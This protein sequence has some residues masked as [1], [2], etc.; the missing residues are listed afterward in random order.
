MALIKKFISINL[1]LLKKKNFY[2]QSENKYN[3]TKFGISNFKPYQDMQEIDLAPITLIYGQNSGG[4]TSLIEAL[5]CSSQSVDNT[6]I[7]KGYFNLS[8]SNISL[9]TYSTVKNKYAK[10]PYI[11][12]KFQP[13]LVN[14]NKRRGLYLKSIEPIL[15]PNIILHLKDSKRINSNILFIEKIELEYDGY[16]KGKNII[17]ES[18]TEGYIFAN[19]REKGDDNDYFTMHKYDSVAK[20]EI[21]KDSINNLKEISELSI[22]EISKELNKFSKR[23]KNEK[24]N[25]IIPSL[26]SQIGPM[27]FFPRKNFLSESGILQI[28]SIISGGWLE[29]KREG[30][31][32]QSF[33]FN[34]S[35]KLLNE[36][37]HSKLKEHANN[38]NNN[39]FKLISEEKIKV[40]AFIDSSEDLRG[41]R[42]NERVLLKFVID[43][44]GVN[45]K[46]Q[47]FANSIYENFCNQIESYFPKKPTK[48]ILIN[49]K[50]NLLK[51]Y[52]EKC[53]LDL[54]TL[55]DLFNEYSNSLKL[56]TK[57][58]LKAANKIEES[59]LEQ[60]KQLKKQLIELVNI[61]NDFY[62]IIEKHNQEIFFKKIATER[63]YKITPI[64]VPKFENRIINSFE[65]LVK[66][67]IEPNNKNYEFDVNEKLEI[68]VC[69][70]IRDLKKLYLNLIFDINIIKLQNIISEN[71]IQLNK[72]KLKFEEMFACLEWLQ[73]D[74]DTSRE[75]E[76]GKDITTFTTLNQKSKIKKF[77]LI[78]KESCAFPLI[79]LNLFPLLISSKMIHLGAARSGGKRIYDFDDIDKCTNSDVGFFLK[80]S[81]NKG[82][83]KDIDTLL[84]E[85]KIANG[86]DSKLLK[87]E[88]HDLKEIIIYPY[89]ESIDTSDKN[90]IS[91]NL[92]DTGYGISQILPIIINSIIINSSTILIQQPE[93]HLHP[94]LQAEVGTIISKSINPRSG[95]RKKALS[96]SR[97]KKNWVV[98]THSETLLFRLLKEIRNGNLNKSDLN[99]LYIDHNN[100]KGSSIKKMLISD[101]GELLS[102]WPDGFFSTDINEIF[103]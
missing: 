29:E 52:Q 9:G 85:A 92:V 31:S 78:K 79:N 37:F 13:K 61:Y 36:K 26:E 65:T 17:F 91:I 74:M 95:D 40:S 58:T 7:E 32:F 69:E 83:K 64:I 96:L 18:K 8:G 77:D 44:S 5:L 16:L 102:Q 70:M 23:N 47:N 48:N 3:K 55:Q 80:L 41:R 86:I 89:D 56:D 35:N 25:L 4:K 72:E 30:I 88:N 45:E 19:I 62:Q 34:K 39:Y 53:N 73:N 103:D 22:N 59:I 57:K 67:E 28:A 101:E 63:F 11:F 1:I 100:Q 24:L 93:T 20:Y 99:V 27:R 42:R 38:I 87:D 49:E 81:D 14:P 66:K 82:Y 33:S 54:L 60:L 46:E 71:R 94:R 68:E 76:W 97:F 15:C 6:D 51:I 43:K 21:K 10:S 75:L 84:R 2:M 12:L 50:Y 98:E 90:K